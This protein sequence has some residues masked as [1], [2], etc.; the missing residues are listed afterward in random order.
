MRTTLTID[1]DVAV[2]LQRL[3]TSRKRGLKQIVNE[4]LR[5]GLKEMSKEQKPHGNYQTRSVS[6]GRCLIG[7]IDDVAEV[8][9]IAEGENFR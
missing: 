9:A 3:R 5:R 2:Q 7:S 8:L 6:L 1:D 4:A